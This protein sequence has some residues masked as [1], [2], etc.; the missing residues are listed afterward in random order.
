MQKYKKDLYSQTIERFFPK[1][2]SF[3]VIFLVT[4]Q[5][6]MSNTIR[7]K[8]VVAAVDGPHVQVSIV[9]MSACAACKVASVCHASEMKEKLVDV[10]MAGHRLQVGDEV[11]VMASMQTAGR[12]LLLGFGYP[13]AL[14]LVVFVIARW[15]GCSEPVAALAMMGS[16]VPYYIILWCLRGRLARQL[17]FTIEKTED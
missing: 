6:Q 3:F 5:A 10:N 7:H 2:S 9:Q 13:L 1:K 12:A 11:V 4:L 14:M 17:T 16:L 8:G 15:A